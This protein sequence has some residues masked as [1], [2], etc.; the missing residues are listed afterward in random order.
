MKNFG[1]NLDTE[2]VFQNDG[3]YSSLSDFKRFLLFVL[4]QYL[5][6]DNTFRMYYDPKTGEFIKDESYKSPYKKFVMDR[7]N[8]KNIGFCKA[9]FAYS[10]DNK[11]LAVVSPEYFMIHLL[12]NI[13]KSSTELYSAFLSFQKDYG[14]DVLDNLSFKKVH[15]DLYNKY[16]SES[17]KTKGLYKLTEDYSET[18]LRA[19][20]LLKQIESTIDAVEIKLLDYFSDEFDEW[21]DEHYKKVEQEI[22]EKLNNTPRNDREEIE[23]GIRTRYIDQDYL[24]LEDEMQNLRQTEAQNALNR[25]RKAFAEKQK[26]ART[27][28]IRILENQFKEIVACYSYL[29]NQHKRGYITDLGIDEVLYYSHPK[30]KHNPK[31]LHDEVIGYCAE[32]YDEMYLFSEEKENET[33]NENCETV[34]RNINM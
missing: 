9:G 17:E 15:E 32:D 7:I 21:N 27:E 22:E 14:N 11:E 18:Y 24:K 20:I 10:E 13:K 2:K 30:D 31:R 3:F 34:I 16:R 4:N 28:L 12:D 26:I 23:N 5:M 33:D 29:D 6:E 1:A 25:Y 19:I 8:L